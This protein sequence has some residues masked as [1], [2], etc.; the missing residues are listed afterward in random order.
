MNAKNE[1]N[2]IKTYELIKRNCSLIKIDSLAVVKQ[3]EAYRQFWKP[4]LTNVILLAESHVYTDGDDYARELNQSFIQKFLS[5]YP[6]RFVRFVYCLGYGED[7]LLTKTRNNRAN[8]GTPQFWKIF[9][10][11]VAE[12]PDAPGHYKVLKTGTPYFAERL[13]NKISILQKMRER[14]IWLLDSSIVGLYGNEAKS[15]PPACG[16]IIDICWNNYIEHIIKDEKPK[17][18]IVIGKGVEKIIGYKLKVPY[19]AI[20]LPSAHIPRQK[21]I[22]N[23]RRYSQICNAVING[24]PVPTQNSLKTILPKNPSNLTSNINLISPKFPLQKTPPSYPKTA[25]SIVSNRLIALGYSSITKKEWV[26]TNKTVDV[27]T[28]VDFGSHIRIT[29]KEKWENDH[30]VIY[31]YSSVD[32]PICIIP[33]LTLFQNSFIR[34]KR[35]TDAYKNSGYW[36]TQKFPEKHELPQLVIKHQNRWDLLQN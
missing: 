1:D 9:C 4:N 10:S 32:G 8:A 17:Y 3:V 7:L 34:D 18:V 28:S 36:W 25:N 2:L 30:A 35:K 16:K 5:N 22:E 29:W 14:G 24:K 23:L 26:K 15:N 21:R 11:C 31:D 33:V 20:D 13:K 19:E 6:S 12:N 27:V